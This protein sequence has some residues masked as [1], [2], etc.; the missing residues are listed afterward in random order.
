MAVYPTPAFEIPAAI[1][2]NTGAETLLGSIASNG[3]FDIA[4]S[5]TA[6]TLY[7]VNNLARIIHRMPGIRWRMSLKVLIALMDWV[8][9]P[10]SHASTPR[11]IRHVRAYRCTV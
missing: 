5:A 2:V 3:S 9:T 10:S 8:S 1:D 4:Y 6:N 11:H 7:M